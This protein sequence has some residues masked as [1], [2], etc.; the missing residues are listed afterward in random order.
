MAGRTL[1]V[2]EAAAELGIGPKRLFRWLREQRVLDAANVPYTHIRHQGL[3][4]VHYGHWRH[5]IVGYR[6]Y[7]RPLVTPRGLEWLRHRLKEVAA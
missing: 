3:M 5:P 6:E 4:R 7:A 1:T 2:Q